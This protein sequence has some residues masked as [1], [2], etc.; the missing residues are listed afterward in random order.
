MRCVA[1]KSYRDL[2]TSYILP[3]SI[4]TQLTLSMGSNESPGSDVCFACRCRRLEHCTTLT[5]SAAQSHTDRQTVTDNHGA[6]LRHSQTSLTIYLSFSTS[7]S[8]SHTVNERSAFAYSLPPVTGK[9]RIR[10]LPKP[11]STPN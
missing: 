1:F 4:R 9:Q 7:P 3:Q 8:L 2:Y 10:Q 5:H 6:I 11:R